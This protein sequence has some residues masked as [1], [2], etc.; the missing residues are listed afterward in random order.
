MKV[1]LRVGASR[2]PRFELPKSPGWLK[3]RTV[4]NAAAATGAVVLVAGA[5][6]GSALFVD[7][8][9]ERAVAR[10]A[11]APSSEAAPAA[12]PVNATVDEATRKRPAE[13]RPAPASPATRPADGEI[14]QLARVANAHA[15][16]QVALAAIEAEPQLPSFVTALAEGRTTDRT[17]T[18]AIP[19]RPEETAPI[20]FGPVADDGQAAID[21]GDGIGEQAAIAGAEV[22]ETAEPDEPTRTAKVTKYVNLRAGPADEA[23]VL[24]VVPALGTVQVVNCD[25]WCE[26]EF[27]GQRGWIYKSFIR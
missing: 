7:Y 21:V 10:A 17:F 14:E 25:G 19:Q 23:K 1:P 24:A 26:V 12:A 2:A 5:G 27:K 11:A 9:A 18:A 8:L 20:A 13:P 4:R 22:T 3:I 15:E 6:I 16:P